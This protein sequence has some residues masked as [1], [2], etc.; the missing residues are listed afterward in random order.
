[1]LTCV[2]IDVKYHPPKQSQLIPGIAIRLNRCLHLLD[3]Y[4]VPHQSEECIRKELRQSKLAANRMKQYFR[5][6][7][8]LGRPVKG[9]RRCDY[10][11]RG[12]VIV[13]RGYVPG[14]FFQF[15]VEGRVTSNKCSSVKNITHSHFNH[16]YITIIGDN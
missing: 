14:I 16:F 10:T 15:F 7:E 1:M 13:P 11:C 2:S 9:L 8:S 12:C 5:T 6:E 3:Q 4:G